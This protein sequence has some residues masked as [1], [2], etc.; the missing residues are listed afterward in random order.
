[1]AT[2]AKENEQAWT[3]AKSRFFQGV[4]VKG[5]VEQLHDFGAFLSIPGTEFP[6]VI[7]IASLSDAKRPL[8]VDDFPQVGTHVRAIVIGH[9]DAGRQ[10]A[11]SLRKS[12]FKRFQVKRP[13]PSIQALLSLSI[14]FGNRHFDAKMIDVGNLEAELK[15]WLFDDRRAVWRLFSAG[16]IS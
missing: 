7:V 14:E 8:T 6:G 11:L 5:R 1:M 9:R 12:D 4:I 3:R 10:I 15:N 13:Q 2:M 16:L